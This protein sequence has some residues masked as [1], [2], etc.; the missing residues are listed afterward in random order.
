MQENRRATSRTYVYRYFL[1]A[2][3]F[4]RWNVSRHTVSS[5]AQQ[6]STTR[7]RLSESGMRAVDSLDLFN[8]SNLS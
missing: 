6:V 3:R 8:T 5:G 1:V 7:A 4:L 2:L